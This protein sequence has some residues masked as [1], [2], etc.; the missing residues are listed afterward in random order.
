MK[1]VILWLIVLA[2]SISIVTS[3]SLV[4]CKKAEEAVVP[5]E[6]VAEEVAKEE[7]AP[8]DPAA[9]ITV[10]ELGEGGEVLQVTPPQGEGLVYYIQYDLVNGF[11]IA[12]GMYMEKFAKELGYDFKLLNPDGKSDEQIDQ[13]DTAITMKAD[14]IIIK[15]IDVAALVGVI[16]K[17]REAGITVL[18]YDGEIT[19]TVLDLQS[20]T[21]TI[22]LGKIAA[23]ESLRMLRE[24]Y[25]EEKGKVLQVMGDLVTSYTVLIDKGFSSVMEENPDV[26][27]VT[28]ST[29]GWEIT[30]AANIVA[31]Q[32]TVSPD[33][34]VIFMHADSR[35]TGVIPVLEGKDYEKGDI[36]L[37]GTDGDPA[38]LQQIRD[39]WITETIAQPMIQQVYGCF[40]FLD[41][42]LAGEEL[43][44][45]K[46]DIKGLESDLLLKNWG[47]TLYLPPNLV[48]EDNVDNPDLWGN[49]E[50]E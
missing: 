32:L 6:E 15:P 50:L 36:K 1:K 28:K 46:Y 22:R 26:V 33:I 31:D 23:E 47:P 18:T 43:K 7:A 11:C 21:G 3:F 42:V 48:T 25:G 13:I 2:V 29:I 5:A 19:D 27:V 45:G 9:D 30:E 49:V 16:D 12:S 10:Q 40:A 24:K 44:E 34:D 20:A 37:I 17:A 39:G 41:K 4:G 35:L 8:T 38:A 14:A